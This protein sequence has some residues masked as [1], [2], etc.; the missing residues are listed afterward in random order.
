[1]TVQLLECTLR[2]GSYEIDFQFSAAFTRN[3]CQKLEELNFPYIEIGHGMGIGAT[4][5]IRE[6]AASD[7]Q[8]AR[9]AAAVTN[10]SLWGMFAIPGIAQVQDVKVLTDEGMNFIRVG[11][12]ALEMSQ[13]IEFL[14]G[15]R[16][17]NLE[18]YVNFMKSYALPIDK[19]VSRINQVL[20]YDIDGVYLVDSAGGMLPTQI[21]EIGGELNK[22]QGKTKL[23]FHGHDNLGLA[24]SNSI[25]LAEKQFDL[26]DCTMQGIGRSAGNASTEK[27]ISIMS[28]MGLGIDYDVIEVLKAGEDFIRPLIPHAGHSGLDTMAGYV[29]FHTSYMDNLLKTCEEFDADPYILMQE[30][31]KTNLVSGGT[32]EFEALIEI[33]EKSEKKG[34]FKRSAKRYLG[35]EQ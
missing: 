22:F 28:R 3:F 6:A 14:E 4:K 15:I 11:I 12:D 33:L 10:R 16:G 25:Q 32:G 31:C 35:N 18:V 13:G 2:D 27:L 26:I 34:S 29:L 23:G 20:D 1:M 21:D 24:I 5:K 8:Y 30:H 19:I 7:I 17:L 9:A